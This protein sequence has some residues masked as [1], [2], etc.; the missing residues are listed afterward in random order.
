[1]QYL[2][3]HI[4]P[5]QY[6]EPAH[7]AEI[8]FSTDID[9]V[10]LPLTLDSGPKTVAVSELGNYTTA[11]FTGTKFPGGFGDTNIFAENDYWLLRRRSAQLFTQNLY[12]R[13]LIRR[14]VTNEINIGLFPEARP[15]ESVLGKAED[16]LAEWSEDVE[17]RFGLWAAS[18]QV[19][20]W[21]RERS[22]GALQRVARAEALVAG[23]VLVVQRIDRRTQM[24]SIQLISGDVVNTPPL[25]FKS[26][27]GHTIMHGVERDATG[28]V[29]GYW[30]RQ[31]T[32]GKFKRL[33]AWG[34][35]SGRRL[36]WLVFGTDR[37]LDG[38]RG[39]PLLSIVM[40]S[41]KEID[42]YRDSTQRKAV[43]NS[44]VAMAVTKSADKMGTLPLQGG[45]VKKQ[46]ASVTDGDNT[47][48][49]LNLSSMMPGMVIDEMQM[50]EDVKFFG[51][52]GTDTE[53]GKFESTILG[54][55]A[56][57]NEMPPEILQLAF[58]SNY[59][60]SQAAINEFKIYLNKFWAEWGE[61]FCAPI[62]SAFLVS[63]VLQ[64][65]V[66]ADSL[67][68]AWADPERYEELAAWVAADW[69]GS[70]KPSTDMHKA[71]KGAKTL[72]DEGWSNNAREARGMTGTKFSRNIK[73]LT[74]ENAQKAKAMEPLITMRE[75]LR[76]AS[77]GTEGPDGSGRTDNALTASADAISEEIDNQ[78]E[79]IS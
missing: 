61:A 30:V 13:G 18:E 34:E 56:W 16:S 38:E 71:T 11:P 37:R 65:K 14:F 55:V 6:G 57:A 3:Q 70:V 25:P 19:C 40:Q 10:A 26:R 75:K 29:F 2:G 48:R 8:N 28:R 15:V 4:G 67:I 47:A 51:G 63:A 44:M 52:Q 12:A 72:V 9:P 24:P 53:F 76:A 42:T 33:P 50:G 59:S 66:Q 54:A 41:L 64:R 20:D 62:Y 68:A 21:R 32:T 58:S 46:S 7:V 45:A 23:D 43:I 49:Q 1:M 60:A 69:Y 36:A 73:R 31:K 35:R 74:R 78:L 17:D 5:V 77:E 39:Q 22:F 27:P 79:E